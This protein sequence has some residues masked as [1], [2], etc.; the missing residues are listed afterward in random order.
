M[1]KLSRDRS[2]SYVMATKSE[3]KVNA[4]GDQKFY[5]S[6]KWR[7]R[8]IRNRQLNPLCEVAEAAEETREADVTDHLIPISEGGARWDDRNL[9]SMSHHYHHKKRGIESHGLNVKTIST[10]GGLIP[11]DR[12]DIIN[13][14]L[15][16]RAK[17]D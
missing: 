10:D 11:A 6:W 4:T 3:K 12:R 5:N 9:M 8:S 7:Q 15:H 16:G 1:P 17:L 13:I 14:L 2:R